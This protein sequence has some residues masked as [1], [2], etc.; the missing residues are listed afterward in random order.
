MTPSM[1]DAYLSVGDKP[2]GKSDDTSKDK[3]VVAEE[4]VEEQSLANFLLATLSGAKVV[5][6]NVVKEDVVAEEEVIAEGPDYISAYTNPV[7]AS[8]E[9]S[10][11]VEDVVEEE[12]IIA[13]VE[14]IEDDIIEEEIVEEEIVEEEVIEEEAEEVIEEE[15][16]E[17][18]LVEDEVVEVVEDAQ[19][20]LGAFIL[21]TIQN[22]IAKPEAEVIEEKPKSEKIDDPNEPLSEFIRRTI[23]EQAKSAITETEKHFDDEASDIVENAKSKKAAKK[24]LAK[25][26]KEKKEALAAIEERKDE[27]DEASG[28]IADTVLQLELADKDAAELDEYDPEKGDKR[29]QGS[30]KA[31]KKELEK[32]I[33]KMFKE[34][35]IATA[36]RIESMSG[37]GSG[38]GGGSSTL[39]TNN[40]SSYRCDLDVYYY[41]GWL[42]DGSTIVIKRTDGDDDEFATGLTDLETDWANRVNL[43][44]I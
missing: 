28:T 15:V 16:E 39:E 7:I 22:A 11:V 26:D 31:L 30:Q 13:E 38:G 17:E 33:K 27:I 32:S 44:Y 40:I 25:V 42:V 3:K 1:Y 36:K 20:D 34:E 8:G 6:D 35:R 4:V 43:T 41:S 29:F 2:S 37:G 10:T 23:A 19:E 9:E 14:V 24:S 12:E 5:K 21:S 18:E